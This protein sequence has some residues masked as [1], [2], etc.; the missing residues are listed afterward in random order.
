MNDQ[1][2]REIEDEG[3]EALWNDKGTDDCPYEY[4]SEEWHAWIGAWSDAFE[5][6]NPEWRPY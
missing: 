3:R 6:S 4:G 5:A 2:R 1:R